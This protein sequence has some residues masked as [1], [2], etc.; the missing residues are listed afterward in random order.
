LVTSY[1]I[2]IFANVLNNITM[3]KAK[4]A[5][6]AKTASKARG[7]RT[8]SMSPSA[9]KAGVTGNRSRYSCGGKLK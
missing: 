5:K 6:A 7:G 8:T 1:L 9:P 3:A 4:I 2:I